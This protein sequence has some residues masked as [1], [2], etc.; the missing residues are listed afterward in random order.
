M[1][2]TA[3]CMQLI[4][5]AYNESS[6]QGLVCVSGCNSGAVD[7]DNTPYSVHAGNQMFDCEERMQFLA[8]LTPACRRM[9]ISACAAD[10]Q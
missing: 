7:C 6:T 1:R 3:A 4:Y 8:M 9:G 10:R 2:N 5:R